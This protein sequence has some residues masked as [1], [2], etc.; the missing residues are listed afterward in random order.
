MIISPP[1]LPTRGAAQS[2]TDWLDAAFGL[3]NVLHATGAP[4]GSF[5]LSSGLNW[6]N[7]LHVM[8]QSDANNNVPVRAIADGEVIFVDGL[9]T[10]ENNDANHA[11]NYNP[12]GDTACWTDNGLVI[13]R[14]TTEIGDNSNSTAP[15][16]LTYYS[17]YM[18]LSRLQTFPAPQAQGGTRRLQVGDR[19]FRKDEIG[20]AG[21]IYGHA[22]QIHL[23]ICLNNNNLQHLIGRAPAWV[24][25]A[26]IPAPTANGRTDAVFGSTWIYLPA[27][28][29]VLNATAATP[30]AATVPDN[31]TLGT[32]LWVEI[33]Y[34]GNATLTSYYATGSQAG[35]PLS[36]PSTFGFTPAT[37]ENNGEYNLYNQA[38]TCHQALSAAD[39]AHSSPS[40][41]Y[42]LLRF[43]RN[44][45]PDPLPANAR[46]WRLIV[47]P[48]GELWTDLNAPGTFKFS[49]ADFLPIQGWNCINDDTSPDD[50]HCDSAR[51]KN[52]IADPNPATPN[53]LD[54]ETL[55][56]RLG[57][58]D[59]R[60]KL[61][62]MICQFPSEWNQATIAQRYDF[63][64]QTEAF[65]NAPDAWGTFE[66]HLNALTFTGLPQEYLDAQWRLHPKEFI[67]WMRRCGWLSHNE[68]RQLVPSHSIR[69]GTYQAAGATHTGTFWESNPSPTLLNDHRI[70]LNRVM[71]KYGISTP[72]RMAGFFGNSIQE[73]RWLRTLS[74]DG[75]S[76][77]WYAPWYGRGFL[78][79]TNPENYCNYWAWRGDPIDNTLRNALV[80]AY[81]A[82]AQQPPAQ[83]SNATLQDQHFPLLTPAIQ[84]RRNAVAAAPNTPENLIA[85]SESAGFYWI[86]TRMARYADEINTLERVVVTAVTSNGQNLGSKVYYRSQNFWRVSAAVNLPGRIN[87]TQYQGINGFNSRCCAWGVAIA[88]LTESLF[89]N[90]QGNLVLAYPEG[91]VK[92]IP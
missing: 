81:A 69:V 49:D 58:P 34:A 2:E 31:Q 86:K 53:R 18:H 75:G 38:N 17:A 35:Q 47:T 32:A 68:M 24:D 4:E 13:L 74:E 16:P 43:G 64:R 89:P 45:G 29:P 15:G 59:V 48:Q 85:P 90:A 91:Y 56:R 78:Q 39:Q 26:N 54:N 6:H 62:R 46:H 52:L 28:T 71:R 82:I 11:Q 79:L 23:E 80:A 70:P 60:R 33:S 88:V 50:Q 40:G 92:V 10:P 36:D 9:Q 41:W 72:I 84:D 76:T 5:P 14:H 25:P 7:G 57:N 44:L 87:N 37:H 67:G 8:G 21:K 61:R 73:T 63:Y 66:R 30:T 19:V 51:L 12:F 77:L 27:S 20:K 1:F 83:R 65:Q 42:E 3:P 22:G 55:S